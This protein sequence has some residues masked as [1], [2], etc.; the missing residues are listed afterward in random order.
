MK[1]KEVLDRFFHVYAMNVIV[2][3]VITFLAY[4]TMLSP[5]VD[6][7]MMYTN[8]MTNYQCEHFQIFCDVVKNTSTTTVQNWVTN[9]NNNL[10]KNLFEWL[11]TIN[12]LTFSM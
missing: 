6:H 4:F 2:T 5:H 3:C 10:K 1:V 8:P 9:F 12:K 7:F 11:V